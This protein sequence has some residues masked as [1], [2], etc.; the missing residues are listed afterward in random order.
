MFSKTEPIHA[1]IAPIVQESIINE[2]LEKYPELEI[3]PI[4]S[5]GKKGEGQFNSDI[6]LAIRIKDAESLKLLIEDIFDYIPVVTVESLYIVS[7]PYPYE[8]KNEL[9]YVQ[10]D[11]MIMWDREYT[12]FRYKCPDYS[13]NESNY[14]VGAKI[15]FA[16][17]LL[18]HCLEEKN[19]NLTEGQFGK[20]DFRP[21]ALYRFIFDIN[22]SKWKEEFITTNP[23]EIAGYAFKDS[24]ISHFDT[25]ESLWKEV[26]SDNFKYPDEVKIIE[27]NW[28]VNC[29]R[30]GWTSIIPEDFELQYW[31]NDEILEFVNEQKMVNKINQCLQ[32]G[33]EI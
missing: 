13:K 23:T 31:T 3:L 4:G 21:T 8:F 18:N 33:R 5:V 24:D 12:A 25:V 29:R 28:F 2:M 20:F 30:K 11:F 10:C 27:K 1:E 9:K 17:M 16:N 6:D 14:K 15:M 26:H 32:I 19:K 7:I 22:R